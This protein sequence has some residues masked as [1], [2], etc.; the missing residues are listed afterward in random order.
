MTEN[1]IATIVFESSLKVHKKLGP[2]L[3]ESAYQ[4]CLTYEIQKRN[5]IVEKQKP[6]PLVYDDVKLDLGY[7][8]DI[9]IENKFIVEL[10]SVDALNEI[11]L[12]QIL[13]YLKLS[14]CKLG[15][16]INFNVTLLKHGVKRVINGYF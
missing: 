9:M 1:E 15:M 14:N 7:R 2:G 6:L 11:H 10:K 8:S 3:L 4:E 16:L 12:A 5:L 13:T